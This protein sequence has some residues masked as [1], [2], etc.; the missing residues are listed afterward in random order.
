MLGA[1][2]YYARK[3]T[4]ARL[5]LGAGSKRY[6]PYRYACLN[7]RIHPPSSKHYLLVPSFA[8]LFGAEYRC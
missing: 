8:R 6:T 3:R 1:V 4:H 7:G 5:D 2:E